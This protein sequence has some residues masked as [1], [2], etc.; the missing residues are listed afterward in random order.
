MASG[1]GVDGIATVSGGFNFL[2]ASANASLL[3]SI[4]PSITACAPLAFDSLVRSTCS[5]SANISRAVTILGLNED[6]NFGSCNKFPISFCW[7]SVI[8]LDAGDLGGV[9]PKSSAATVSP[10]QEPIAEP[11]NV[12]ATPPIKP[13]ITLPIP[14]KGAPIA[15]PIDPRTAPPAAPPRNEPMVDPYLCLYC[16]LLIAPVEYSCSI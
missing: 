12:P 15:A 10:T 2:Y 11:A 3:S 9:S 5:E 6:L 14:N 16:S 8:L 4:I 7:A 13:N 1:D